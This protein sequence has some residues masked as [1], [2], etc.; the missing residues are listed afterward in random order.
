MVGQENTEVN[1]V[2]TSGT[3]ERALDEK[4]SGKIVTLEAVFPS[5]ELRGINSNNSFSCA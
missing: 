1:P 5:E 2:G 4:Q 3:G